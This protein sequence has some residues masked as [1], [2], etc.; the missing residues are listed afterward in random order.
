M[1]LSGILRVGKEVSERHGDRILFAICR[2]VTASPPRLDP[3]TVPGTGVS[4]GVYNPKLSRKAVDLVRKTTE[5]VRV[6]L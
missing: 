4:V 5:K 3:K 1:M 2:E 6:G